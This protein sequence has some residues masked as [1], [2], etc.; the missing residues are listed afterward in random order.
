MMLPEKLP[1][2]LLLEITPKCN[3][4]CPFCYCLWHEFPELSRNVMTN[5]QWKQVISEAVG[6]G[7]RSF[8]FTGGEPLLR[9]GFTDLISHAR[10]FPDVQLELF[11]NASRM[12]PELLQYFKQQRVRLA[13]SLQGLNTYG[14]MTG[15]KRK[16]YRTIDFI[17]ECSEMKFPCSVGV[18]V[19]SQNIIEAENIVSAAIFAGAS[20]VQVSVFMFTGR[21]KAN[22]YLRISP[23]DWEQ[24]KERLKRLPGASAVVFGDEFECG[25]MADSN[26]KCPAGKS[27]GVVSP[28]GTFRKCLHYYKP[29]TDF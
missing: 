26:Y 25:C 29:K 21:G 12:T 3:Y 4:S 9:R 18:T 15:T 23:E 10:S 1:E 7:C 27:F 2:K 20:V 16:F 24:L 19:T 13:T 22:S 11:T 17:A 6:K 14:E 28:N 8:L 5:R